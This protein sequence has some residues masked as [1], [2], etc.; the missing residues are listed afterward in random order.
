MSEDAI[1]LPVPHVRWANEPARAADVPAVLQRAWLQCQQSPRGPVFVSI[2]ED[3]WDMEAAPYVARTAGDS[4]PDL[5]AAALDAIA[6]ALETATRP[7]LVANDAVEA[8][9]CSAQLVALAE[10]L[11]ARMWCGPLLGRKGLPQRHPLFAGELTPTREGSRRQLADFDVVVVFGGPAWRYHVAS[12]GAPLAD[13]TR[14]FVLTDDSKDAAAAPAGEAFVASASRAVEQLSVRL[15]HLPARPVEV[16]APALEVPEESR[17]LSPARALYEISSVLPRGVHLVEESP[18][19]REFMSR[20]LP[21]QNDLRYY[22]ASSGQLGWALPAAAGIA[23]ARSGEKVVALLGDGSS[24]YAI[25]ALW[26]IVQQGLDVTVIVLDNG[27]YAALEGLSLNM[28]IVGSPGQQLPGL[29]IATIAR[30]FGCEAETVSA[31][32]D[33]LS[34]LRRAIE[35]PRAQVVVVPISPEVHALYKRGT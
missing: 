5:G 10:R 16:T 14:L 22:A 17:P 34:A 27:K 28:G 20:F 23:L 6:G 31:E 7:A 2:P 15:A 1:K 9:G 24:M 8:E 32:D 18:S 13:G 26:T 35:A 4:R 33:L 12:P 3:D 30:G 29:D 11:G 25:Q 19:Q 21:V